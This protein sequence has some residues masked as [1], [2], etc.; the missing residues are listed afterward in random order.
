MLKGGAQAGRDATRLFAVEVA[1]KAALLVTLDPVPEDVVVH[2]AADIDRV[3]LDV[4]VVGKR[5]AHVRRL[6]IHEVR[7]PQERAGPVRRDLSGRV[8]VP[9]AGRVGRECAGAADA[10]AAEGWA[11]ATE[12]GFRRL[13]R[14]A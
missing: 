7:P 1:H 6:A 2:A 4:A 12:A 5:I 11:G 10:G 3:D 14:P 8:H 13:I 9:G